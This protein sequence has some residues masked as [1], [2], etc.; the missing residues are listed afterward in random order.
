MKSKSSSRYFAKR[1]KDVPTVK[2]L[3][4][5]QPWYMYTSEYLMLAKRVRTFYNLIIFCNLHCLY[6]CGNDRGMY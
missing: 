4:N 6:S 3:I 1:Y 5:Q 2:K